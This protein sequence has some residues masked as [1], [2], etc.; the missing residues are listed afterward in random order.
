MGT[1]QFGL[2]YGVANREG[3]VAKTDVAAMLGY[4]HAHGISMLDT[5]VAYGESEQVLGDVGIDGW[6]VVSKLPA[7]PES[8]TDVRAWVA[9]QVSESLRRLGVTRLYGLLLHRPGQLLEH[10]GDVLYSAIVSMKNK[11]LVEKVGV[12]VYEPAEL[13]RFPAQMQFD[14]VQAPFNIVDSRMTASGWLARLSDSGCEVHVRSVFLQ[15]L[16]LMKPE[17]R[18]KQ[19]SPW[20]GLWQAWDSWLLHAGLTP[21]QACLRYALST[22]GIAK[23]VLGVDSLAQL[24]Q[25]LAAAKGDMPAIPDDLQTSDPKLLNPALWMNA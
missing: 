6:D 9:S 24:Q 7:V 19:F 12:S 2:A 15:G 11:G 13:D 4:A 14:L 23:V 21:L 8:V 16:L 25:I 22:P 3:Q 20:N 18:P 10:R 17:E 5:A 1:A